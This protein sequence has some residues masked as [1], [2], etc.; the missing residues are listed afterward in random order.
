MEMCWHEL[1]EIIHMH[2]IRVNAFKHLFI[3][4]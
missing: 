3:E 1:I 2:E 4:V